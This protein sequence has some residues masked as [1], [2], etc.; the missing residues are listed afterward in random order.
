MILSKAATSNEPAVQGEVRITSKND[1]QL[2]VT[3]PTVK[4]ENFEIEQDGDT[5]SD[6]ES[7]DD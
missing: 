6:S 5:D 4:T 3:V 7:D 1:G 2:I